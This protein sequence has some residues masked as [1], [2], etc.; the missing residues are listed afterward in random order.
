MIS[1]RV[2][3]TQHLAGGSC[4]IRWSGP[5]AERNLSLIALN[6]KWCHFRR[7]G[8]ECQMCDRFLGPLL[9]TFMHRGACTQVRG[10][11]EVCQAQG[12]KSHSPLAGL[13]RANRRIFSA[14][15]FSSMSHFEGMWTGCRDLLPYKCSQKRFLSLPFQVTSYTLFPFSELS[16]TPSTCPFNIA[17]RV[18]SLHTVHYPH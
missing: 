1:L 16:N 3:G 14:P 12:G 18:L 11:G 17:H 13:G 15:L 4:S 2:E 6:Y 5:Y 9:Q 10:L 7:S 8:A